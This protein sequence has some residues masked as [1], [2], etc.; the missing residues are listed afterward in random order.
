MTKCVALVSK[1]EL[2]WYFRH[3]SQG[4]AMN[5]PALLYLCPSNTLRYSICLS[6]GCYTWIPWTR[7]GLK[8]QTITSHSSRGWQVQGM[9]SA[10]GPFP[11]VDCQ[12]LVSPHSGKRARELS[13]VPFKRARIPFMWVPPLWPNDLLKAPPPNTVTWGTRI[14]THE[15]WRDTNT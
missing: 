6:L 3:L 5:L 2:C 13:G 8:Q 15:C 7:G 14:A 10:E 4:L 1:L 12:L 11:V 9:G